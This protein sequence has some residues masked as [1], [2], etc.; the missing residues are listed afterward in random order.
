MRLSASR[1]C[2]LVVY[3]SNNFYSIRAC[4]FTLC[5]DY[6]TLLRKLTKDYASPVRFWAGTELVLIVHD[7][8]DIE[9]IFKSSSC[10]KRLYNYDYIRDA[11]SDKSDGLF[12]SHGST[13]KS[14]RRFVSQAFGLH[15]IYSHLPIFNEHMLE[16][17]RSLG[18]EAGRPEFDIR[19]RLNWATISMFLESMLGCDF[20]P[21][22]KRTFST[23]LTE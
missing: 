8:T 11:I 10:M 21:E 20:S 5:T 22:E 13:W 3:G 18:E 4:L 1:T 16:L 12:T 17:V 15:M 7:R 23:Y 14:H 9:T 19:L 6:A 2:V